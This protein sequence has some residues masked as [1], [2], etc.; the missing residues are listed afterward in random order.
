MKGWIPM[1]KPKDYGWLDIPQVKTG[2]LPGLLTF[3]WVILLFAAMASCVFAPLA[4]VPL[5]LSS[6][7]VY[8]LRA[9][10]VSLRSIETHLYHLSRPDDKP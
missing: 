7:G 1:P 4:A 3:L 8:C 2:Y 9:V 5:L 6:L 10:I